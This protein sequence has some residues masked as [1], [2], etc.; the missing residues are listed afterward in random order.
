[1]IDFQEIVFKNDHHKIIYFTYFKISK[2]LV[3]LVNTSGI[4]NKYAYN[5]NDEN[6]V[7]G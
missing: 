7:T 3:N 5:L 6:L 2:L 1:L 4:D